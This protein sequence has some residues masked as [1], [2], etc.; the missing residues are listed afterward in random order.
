M[1]NYLFICLLIVAVVLVAAAQHQP[2]ASQPAGRFQIII[3]PNVRADTFL[4]DTQ[5]G[6]IWRETEYPDLKDK[7]TAWEYEERLDTVVDLTAWYGAHK[8]ISSESTPR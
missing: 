5:T 6:K 3:N 7:P 8:P 2:I 1:K 4:L